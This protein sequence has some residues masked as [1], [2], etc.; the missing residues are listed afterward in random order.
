MNNTT[1]YIE[2]DGAAYVL[3]IYETH[4]DKA[5][6]HYEHAVLQGLAKLTLPYKTPLPVISPKGETYL[7]LAAE[8]AESTGKL[9]ALF[10]YMDG[11]RPEMDTN[12]QIYS[13]GKATAELG[14]VLKQIRL[15][16]NPVVRGDT[17]AF[18]DLSSV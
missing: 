13:F 11:D 8:E 18:L 6:V 5:K 12:G 4:R 7:R 16:L 14:E 9:A 15:L 3:R 1:C 2:A 10:H 17:N